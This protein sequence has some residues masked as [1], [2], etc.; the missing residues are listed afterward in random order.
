MPHR[1]ANYGEE[2]SDNRRAEQVDQAERGHTAMVISGLALIGLI[3]PYFQR[4]VAL[5]S[6]DRML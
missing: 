2:V 6:S 5:V 1:H 3:L 4:L